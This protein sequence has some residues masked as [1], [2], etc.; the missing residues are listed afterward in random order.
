MSLI[1]L[2]DVP[3]RRE[4]GSVEPPVR[5]T[6]R[7]ASDLSPLRRRAIRYS[8]D[9]QRIETSPAKPAIGIDLHASVFAHG[10]DLVARDLGFTKCRNARSEFRNDL[11][12]RV[13]LS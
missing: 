7:H 5:P 10:H 8:S 11:S 1:P 9:F 12:H 13:H 3:R 4:D 6:D 2:W